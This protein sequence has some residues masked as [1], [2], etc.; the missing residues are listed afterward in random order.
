MY[1]YDLDK[2]RSNTVE[3]WY[4][5]SREFFESL[6][7]DEVGI[8]VLDSLD[9]L[10]S[11]EMNKRVDERYKAFK[12]GKD[13][14]DGSYQM[15]KAKFLSQEFFPHIVP[16]VEDKKAFLIVISQT[17]DKIGSMFKTKTRAGGKALDFYC[18]TILWLREVCKE[19]NKGI[20]TKIIIEA[21]TKKNKTARPF[22]KTKISFIFD[23]GIDNTGDNIDYLFNLRTD[24]GKLRSS[25]KRIQWEERKDIT[26]K[27]ITDFLKSN[28]NWYKLYEEDNP[29]NNLKRGDKIDAVVKWI[30]EHKDI[31]SEYTKIFGVTMTRDELIDWVEKDEKRKKELTERVRDKWESVEQEIATKRTKKYSLT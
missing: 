11:K 6:K 14:D 25:A 3:D 5:N 31:K 12:K 4:N 23:Y 9:G 26:V 21:K 19:E 30:E 10:S 1:G 22:R 20:P 28:E 24:E 18:H 7:K 29:T 13:F 2:K 17:R 16:L 27:N 8:F 15:G